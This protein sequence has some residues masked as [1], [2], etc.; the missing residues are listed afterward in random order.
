M[1]FTLIT[2][3]QYVRL[4]AKHDQLVGVFHERALVD[5]ERDFKA[6]A[7]L[8][9]ACDT[10]AD[11][12]Q[13]YGVSGRRPHCL[14]ILRIRTGKKIPKIGGSPHRQGQRNIVWFRHPARER[15]GTDA[16]C[17]FD[18]RHSLSPLMQ[19]PVSSPATPKRGFFCGLCGI[20][21]TAPPTDR[22]AYGCGRS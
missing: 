16:H 10:A 6:I 21:G 20:K 7:A 8:E 12:E 3:R 4:I 11:F 1:P 19:P 13:I 17:C 2:S 15:S 22:S 9:D 14:L 5:R 18:G